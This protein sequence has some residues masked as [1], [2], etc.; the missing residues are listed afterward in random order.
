MNLIAVTNDRLPSS[1]LADILLSIH[2]SVDGVILRERSKTDRDVIELIHHLIESGFPREKLIIHRRADIAIICGLH[3]VQL[4]GH[5]IP[6]SLIKNSFPQISFGKS[7][8]SH[9]EA[10]KALEDGADWVLYGHLYN[11]HSKAGVPGR[12]TTELRAILDALTIPVYAIG[13]I[14]PAHIPEL[15]QLGVAGAA[16]MSSIFDSPNPLEAIRRYQVELAV[17]QNKEV[18]CSETN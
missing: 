3:R 1:D 10:M 5:G 12:G 7:I 14:Q 8:H 18:G 17:N 16:I 13:G 9:E 6:P 15:A 2:S 4:P 11:T